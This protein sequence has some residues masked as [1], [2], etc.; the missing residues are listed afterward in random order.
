MQRFVLSSLLMLS[1]AVS[2]VVCAQQTRI[3]SFSHNG[4]LQWT[5]DLVGAYCG[6]ESAEAMGD[7]W[8][9]APPPLW[10][11]AVTGSLMS[12]T[13]PLSE[14][15]GT[16]L[17]LRMVSSTNPLPARGSIAGRVT[18]AE[19]QPL[20]DIAITAF[21]WTGGGWEPARDAGTDLDGRYALDR[22]PAGRYRVKFMD[23][24]GT[25]RTEYYD[26]AADFDSAADVVLEENET[27]SGIHASMDAA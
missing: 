15:E 16:V 12:A 4:V 24:S 6:I 25:Y 9:A 22:L 17:F 21:R 8:T 10:N 7:E 3:V 14:I 11:M 1:L 23:F 5:N 20:Q 19:G 26:G 18:D 27:I 13:I 2:G